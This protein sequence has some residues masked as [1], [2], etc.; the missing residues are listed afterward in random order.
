MGGEFIGL[1]DIYWKALMDS[2]G[3]ARQAHLPASVAAEMGNAPNIC[4][5]GSYTG[6]LMSFETSMFDFP[7]PPR[8]LRWR[9]EQIGHILL[10]LLVIVSFLGIG[11][12]LGFPPCGGAVVCGFIWQPRPS[13]GALGRPSDDFSRANLSNPL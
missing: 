9:G 12:L 1:E 11:Y 8:S 7:P 10:T 13:E 5:N 6:E 3:D 4:H 2:A